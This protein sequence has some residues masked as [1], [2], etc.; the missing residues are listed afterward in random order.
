MS[1][2]PLNAEH[3]IA[4]D[5]RANHINLDGAPPLNAQTL[6][7]IFARCHQIETLASTQFDP[8]AL[9]LSITN[10]QLSLTAAEQKINDFYEWRSQ[11]FFHF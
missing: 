5:I 3:I 11:T 1:Q 7:W 8:T 10:L 4:K 9:N 2:R 6:Q